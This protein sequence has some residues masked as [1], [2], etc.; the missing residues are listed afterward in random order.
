MFIGHPH[1]GKWL[2]G[3][4]VLAKTVT[5]HAL[6]LRIIQL[7][8]HALSA[9]LVAWTLLNQVNFGKNMFIFSFFN[10][11]YRKSTP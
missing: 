3:C 6:P 7:R 1:S 10:L 11:I 2:E 4:F 9:F 8:T 5:G